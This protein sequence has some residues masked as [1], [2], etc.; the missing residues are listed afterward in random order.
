MHAQGVVETRGDDLTWD[1]ERRVAPNDLGWPALRDRAVIDSMSEFLV[2]NDRTQI[3]ELLELAASK[4]DQPRLA[5]LDI[6]GLIHDRLTYQRGSTKV[7]STAREVW[8]L[9]RG[10]CQDYS[11]VAL[12]ALRSIGL[13][14]AT[15]P[16]TSIRVTPRPTSW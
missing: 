1:L 2:V 16:V 3:D 4:A 13:P 7:N 15:C 14:A 6:C 8:E 10:V 11:H 12:G 5:G 9:G